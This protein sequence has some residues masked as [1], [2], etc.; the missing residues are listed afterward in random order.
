MFGRNKKS[1]KEVVISS[2]SQS[3]TS[4]L[5]TTSTEL[6]K[7]QQQ[8]A[9]KKEQELEDFYNKNAQ[10]LDRDQKEIE[11]RAK[12]NEGLRHALES[13]KRMDALYKLQQERVD[14]KYGKSNEPAKEQK[15]KKPGSGVSIFP[16]LWGS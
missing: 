6:S 13:Q 11:E 10:R 4:S 1:S 7:E 2:G 16:F 3:I 9:T 8:L 14:A 5:A 15:L 12:N